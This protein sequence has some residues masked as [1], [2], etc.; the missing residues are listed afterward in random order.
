M[1]F[2]TPVGG[3]LLPTD[4]APSILFAVLYALLVPVMIYRAW[5][6]RSRTT[7]LIGTAIFGIER[8]ANRSHQPIF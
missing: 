7:L 1:P 4:F 3:T 5:D 2:P 6:K 8:Y